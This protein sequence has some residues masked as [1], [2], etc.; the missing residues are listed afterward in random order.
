M[1]EI[2]RRI[3]AIRFRTAWATRTIEYRDLPDLMNEVQDYLTENNL[4]KG[5]AD[6]LYEVST[7]ITWLAFVDR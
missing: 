3:I 5:S 2:Q 1:N 6:E 4:F 7:H